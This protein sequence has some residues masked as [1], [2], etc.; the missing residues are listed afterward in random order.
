MSG[1]KVKIFCQVVLDVAGALGLHADLLSRAPDELSGGQLLKAQ[2]VLE[3]VSPFDVLLLD[4]PTNYLDYDGV[5]ALT[6]F[7][8]NSEAAVVVISHDERFVEGCVDRTYLISDRRF[9]DY[10]DLG[11]Y[12]GK[13]GI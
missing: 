5:R 7:I 1:K 8:R 9:S 2:L 4:E 10:C 13:D 6:E 11:D 3:L 12:F